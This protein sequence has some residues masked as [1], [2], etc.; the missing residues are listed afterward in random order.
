MIWNLFV[1]F[2]HHI[3]FTFVFLNQI[4]MYWLWTT[5]EIYILLS[6][7]DS[8]SHNNLCVNLS[9]SI[10]EKDL[11]TT[12]N[13]DHSAFTLQRKWHAQ[14]CNADFQRGTPWRGDGWSSVWEST[15]P[16]KNQ[17]QQHKNPLKKMLLH[18]IPLMF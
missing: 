9:A 1:F 17:L 18:Y 12:M 15:P 11:N 5:T 14:S 13:V 10:A 4:C 7:S 6:F 8:S 16:P 3:C 2:S